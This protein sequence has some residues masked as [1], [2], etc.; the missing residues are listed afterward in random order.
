M[1]VY[2]FI[3]YCRLGKVELVFGF[4]QERCETIYVH[5]RDI[6]VDEAMIPFKGC[7]A[8]KQYLPLKPVKRGSKVWMLADGHT[9]YVSK[10]DVYTCKKENTIEEG[11]GQSVV[12][13]L[14]QSLETGK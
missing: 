9:G 1:H 10:I 11:L 5:S 12:K 4:L 14:C 6:S 3:S 13:H 7:F 8:I 2:M